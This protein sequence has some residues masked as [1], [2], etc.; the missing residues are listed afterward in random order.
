MF[1]KLDGL[2]MESTIF[3]G[4]LPGAAYDFN[5]LTFALPCSS[6][7]RIINMATPV[8]VA[9]AAIR[10]INPTGVQVYFQISVINFGSPS[11]SRIFFIVSGFRVWRYFL[12]ASGECDFFTDLRMQVPSA[13]YNRWGDV[14]GPNVLL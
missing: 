9:T 11:E 1:S 2:D 7:Y 3:D 6:L 12:S 4:K 5:M 10:L 8:T 14:L 13:R